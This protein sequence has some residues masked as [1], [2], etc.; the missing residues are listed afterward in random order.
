MN[1]NSTRMERL[2]RARSLNDVIVIGKEVGKDIT[3]A[4]NISKVLSSVDQSEQT[5]TA[6]GIKFNTT[7]MAGT[8]AKKPGR[9]KIGPAASIPSKMGAELVS[10]KAPPVKQVMQ[11]STVIHSLQENLYELEAAAAMI[12]TTFNRAK[13]QGPALKAL[14]SLVKEARET[15]EG[16]YNSL[17]HIAQ[18]HLP[19]EMEL[20]GNELVTFLI[21]HLDRKN[22]SNLSKRIYVTAGEDKTKSSS[23]P[24]HLQ[25]GARETTTVG[26]GPKGVVKT[27]KNI[28]KVVLPPKKVPGIR[29]KE[30]GAVTKE[31][32]K[33]DILFSFYI[34]IEDLRDTSGAVLAH[35]YV[36]LTGVIGLS[37]KIRY[38]LNGLPD[39]Q[40]PGLYTPGVEIQTSDEMTRR[41]GML[42]TT[43]DITSAIERKPMPI[44]TTDVINKGFNLVANVE[45]TYVADDSLWVVVKADGKKGTALD[46]VVDQVTNQ[47]FPLLNAA[48]GNVRRTKSVI[49]TK[50]VIRKGKTVVQFFLTP[51]KPKTGE[52]KDYAINADQLTELKE[53][54][55]IP[56]H[57]MDDIKKVL[58]RHI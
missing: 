30:T 3:R 21:D 13:N 14:E 36:I 44:N 56:Q 1:T 34:D 5:A 27:T 20:L 17:S 46:K 11:H 48:V 31:E 52:Q 40:P 55:G 38:F 29:K 26:E 23:K 37:G 54:L 18:K 12:R 47:I 53:S 41:L 39:F 58:K 57:V 50:R 22:Y 6:A 15:L 2:R 19:P 25:F 51:N 28:S 43:N 32:L 7:K 35:Y 4:S 42:L 10:F 9:T 45:Q 24:A 8:E 16:A 33:R 49:K